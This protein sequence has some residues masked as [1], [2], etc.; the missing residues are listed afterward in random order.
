MK[1]A[2]ASAYIPRG[3]QR[4]C[5]AESVH[6]F[7]KLEMLWNVRRRKKVYWDTDIANVARHQN[8]LLK[9]YGPTIMQSYHNIWD[10]P[11]VLF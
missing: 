11:L 4:C 3:A 10:R 6:G 1:S 9:T 5:T 2:N 7:T 8:V